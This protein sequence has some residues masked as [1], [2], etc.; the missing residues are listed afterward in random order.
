MDHDGLEQFA[1]YLSDM[2]REWWPFLF[3]R[4]QQHERMGTRRVG[5]LAALYGVL[6]GV[7]ANVLL[8]LMGHG[9]G[10]FNPLLFPLGATLGFFLIY[11]FT[12]AYFWNRRAERL[13]RGMQRAE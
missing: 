6:A 3:L 10:S 12:F 11:R 1:N 2:D 4:P 7:V 13:S 5:A 9:A 8:A